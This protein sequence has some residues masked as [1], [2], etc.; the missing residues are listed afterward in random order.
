MEDYD[1]LSLLLM[2]LVTVGGLFT[3]LWVWHLF[4]AGRQRARQGT[5]EEGSGQGT[6][7]L[8]QIAIGSVTDFFDTLGIGSYATTTGL[9]KL[10]KQCP[11]RLIPGT[12]TIGHAIPTFLQAWI[13]TQEVRVDPTTL[14]VMIVAAVAGAYLGAGFVAKWSMQRVRV[15]MGSALAVAAVILCYRQIYAIE[16]PG[17]FGLD[18]TLLVAAAAGNFVLGALMTI[19]VGAYAPCMILVTVLGMETK[20]AFPIMMGSCAFLMPVAGVRFMREHSYSPKAALGLALGGL[21][22][23]WIAAKWVKE[24]DLRTV[25]WLVVA[26]VAITAFSM[27]RAARR[28]ATA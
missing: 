16:S 8:I 18:G 7:N 22:A 20:A 5:V 27:L 28:A 9:F 1:L 14:V 23:V 17:S 15:G 3:A 13:Y 19:G 12:L 25:K 26:V 21:P 4:R 11:D 10:L 2:A 24:M 6:P